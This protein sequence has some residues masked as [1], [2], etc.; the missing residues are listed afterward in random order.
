MCYDLNVIKRQNPNFN[1]DQPHMRHKY[2]DYTHPIVDWVNKLGLEKKWWGRVLLRAEATLH[3]R[4]LFVLLVFSFL[5]SWV[6]SFELPMPFSFE[7][8]EMAA[9][10][11]SSPISFQMVDEVSTE[12]QRRNAAA[13]VL[14][15]FEFDVDIF[16]RVSSRLLHAFRALRT[17]LRNNREGGFSSTANVKEILDVQ[18]KIDCPEY[19]VEW[20]KRRDFNIYLESQ[21]VAILDQWF[22]EKIIARAESDQVSRFTTVSLR[23]RQRPEREFIIDRNEFMI[24]GEHDLFRV[25]DLRGLERLSAEERDNLYSFAHLLLVPNVYLNEEDSVARRKA[26]QAMVPPV[27]MS[28]R[29]NQPIISEGNRVT[30]KDLAIIQQIQDLQS[31]NSPALK[32]FFVSLI[33]VTLMLAARSFFRHYSHQRFKIAGKDFFVMAII[34]FGE[35][36]FTKTFLFVTEGSILTR[37][38]SLL[39]VDVFLALAPLASGPILVALLLTSGEVVFFFSLFLGVIV[40]MLVGQSYFWVLCVWITG[41]AAA[42][43]VLSCKTR[44][45]IYFG[46]IRAGIVNAFVI[47]CWQIIQ[48]Y[49]SPNV[50]RDFMVLISAGFFSGILSAMM[51]MIFVPILE[52]LFNYTTDVRLLEL[53][54]LNHPLLRD[55]LVRAPGTYHHSMMV[56]SMVEAAAEE[57]GANP[58]LGKVICYYH[59]IG[60]MSHANYF[61]ENQKVGHNPHDNISPYMSKT[62]LIAH[63]K[64][65]VEMGMKYKLGQPIIDGI[66]QHHGTTLIAF[67]YN[68]ALDLAEDGQIVAEEDFRYPGPKPQFREAALCMLADSIEAAARSL[69]EPTPSRLQNIVRNIIQKKFL[70]GQL[71]ECNLTL[72]DLT[73]VENAF[74][75]I[76]LGIYHQRIDY[77]RE[78]ISQNALGIGPKTARISEKTTKS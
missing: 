28:V 15:V 41:L 43:G 36:L 62:L 59:D 49:Q 48:N 65:G 56:G 22:S 4:R 64:D 3:L 32:S 61:I 73:K 35:V 18:L 33:L 17:E 47:G 67:F 45:D 13:R 39:P 53:S 8:G 58:L 14:P 19:L 69:D 74:V 25:K 11:L 7:V 51:A 46:G 16:D 6:V 21:L 66:L 40:G 34:L 9:T 31:E 24:L 1:G 37:Y 2:E 26:A 30:P 78:S 57:I 60:K 55:M 52:S 12:E 38:S 23:S 75:R 76:L 63:V 54:N 20:L 50:F 29:K 44:N 27:I 10:N 77:P 70:D 72:K 5:I 68:K 71:D 42:R